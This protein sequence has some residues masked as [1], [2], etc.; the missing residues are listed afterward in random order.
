MKEPSQTPR[1][2]L[3]LGKLA[4]RLRD[5]QLLHEAQS[6]LT[7]LKQDALYDDLRAAEKTDTWQF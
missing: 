5:K 4:I 3:L 6:F 1:T 7:F 2:H